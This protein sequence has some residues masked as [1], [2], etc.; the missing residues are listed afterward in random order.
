MMRALPKYA[1]E[2][3]G[4]FVLAFAVSLSLQSEWP[5]ATPI[6][7][8][9]TVGLFVYS[10]GNIS[11]THINP[12]VTI[13]LASIR[14]IDVKDA[15]CYLVAQFLGGVLAMLAAKHYGSGFAPALLVADTP[16]VMAAEAM[17]AFIL[18]FGISAVVHG[19]V[20]SAASGL[21]IGGS[22]LLGILIASVASNGVLNPAVAIGIGSVSLSYLLAPIV[23]A[24][25]A[26]WLFRWLAKA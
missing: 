11:G 25:A 19:K 26:A 3:L 6:I 18:V 12:A 1:A 13:A 2:L 24:L 16:R 20:H 17:G 4:T 7:A 8:A 22:L 14:K 23:G 9:L 21:T 10:V 5:L 15:L